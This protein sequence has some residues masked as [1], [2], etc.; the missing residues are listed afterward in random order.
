MLV[1]PAGHEPKMLA[2]DAA[3]AIVPELARVRVVT[4]P[5][6]EPEL[7]AEEPEYVTPVEVVWDDALKTPV[8]PAQPYL[9]AAQAVTV[10]VLVAVCVAV[11]AKP[12]ARSVHTAGEVRLE[13]AVPVVPVG[14]VCTMT[15][16]ED[17]GTVK[18]PVN[19]VALAGTR[20]PA[21]PVMPVPTG[22]EPSNT[23]ARPGQ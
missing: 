23:L 15:L 16:L 9:P 19:T 11:K 14:H 17:A 21:V 7:I 5:E 4:T 20:L 8:A 13:V 6:V 18:A 1:E 2:P 3:V 12:E 10:G 22:S